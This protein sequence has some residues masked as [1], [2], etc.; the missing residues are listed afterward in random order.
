[1]KDKKHSAAAIIGLILFVT[2]ALSIL[3]SFVRFLM[4]PV[5]LPPDTPFGKVKSDYLLMLLQCVLGLIVSLLPSLIARRWKIL[6]PNFIYV[7]YFIFLYLAIYLGEVWDF[8]YLIPH[9]DTMLHA[10]SGAMLGAL[11]FVLI[12]LLNR[13][14]KVR[15]SL[16]PF[17]VALFA[18]CFALAMGAIWEIYEY[19]FDGAL[20]LNMQK[21]RLADGTVLAGHN[22][23]RDTMKDIIIDALSA[24]GISVIG[25]IY[26]KRNAI[27][28]AKNIRKIT[29]SSQK[30]E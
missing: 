11:G 22:A 26:A 10:F 14:Q 3:Y 29:D 23:L 2:L 30:K 13:D 6:L 20:G 7:L 9:W 19:S 27:I 28:E 16:S 12:D 15:V 17:F 5:A 21:F 8:Y 4:A 1:M 24:F 18:F 25:Y